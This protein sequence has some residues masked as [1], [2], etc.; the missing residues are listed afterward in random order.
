MTRYNY[1]WT[2]LEKGEGFFIPCLDTKEVYEDGL[3]A[4]LRERVFDARALQCIRRGLLGV[5]FYRK[6]VPGQREAPPPASAEFPES[7]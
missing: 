3:K 4:A 2:T 7:A 6:P 5:W 1:P